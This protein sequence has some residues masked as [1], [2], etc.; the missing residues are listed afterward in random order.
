[1]GY[2]SLLTELLLEFC[3]VVLH[4]TLAVCPFESF[5]EL[6]GEL[7]KT[8]LGKKYIYRQSNHGDIEKKLAIL[9]SVSSEFS[10]LQSSVLLRQSNT[11][12]PH[13]ASTREIFYCEICFQP[14]RQSSSFCWIFLV[15]LFLSPESAIRQYMSSVENNFFLQREKNQ[16]QNLWMNIMRCLQK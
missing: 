16:D 6:T 7:Q 12:I 11:I 9:Q 14:E 1:M 13:V 4:L 5:P 2:L 8:Q 10:A 3:P 15:T